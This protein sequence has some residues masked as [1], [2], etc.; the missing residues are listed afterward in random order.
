M[1]IV[2]PVLWRAFDPGEQADLKVRLYETTLITSYLRN[3]SEI[4]IN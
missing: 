3:S 2:T 4:C 1:T